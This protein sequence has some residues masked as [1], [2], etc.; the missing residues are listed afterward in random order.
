MQN[1][2]RATLWFALLLIVGLLFY[3]Q[4]KQ[5]FKVETNILKLLPQ[6]EVDPFAEEAFTRFSDNNFKQLIIAVSASDKNGALDGAQRLS[7][8]L[9]ATKLI[10]SF[11][12]QLTQTEQRAIA[13]LYF[14]HRFYLLSDKDRRLMHEE[15][16][17]PFIDDTLQLIY[18]PLS[19]R[20]VSLIP[21]DPYLL[22][23]RYIQNINALNNKRNQAAELVDE[24][25]V[26]NQ[27]GRFTA[28]LSARISSS[29]FDTDTQNELKG[30]IE[31][32]ERQNNE[33]S[34]LRTGALFYAQHAAASAKQ[35][36]STIGLGSLIAVIVLLLVAFRS[37]VPLLL[38]LS[39]LATGIF[40]ALTVVHLTFSSIHILTLV[41]GSSL[42]GVAVDYSFHYFATANIHQR[43]LKHILIAIT[44]GLISSVIGYVALFTAPFPGL[45][46]MA[47][48][49]AV[50]LAGAFFTVVLLFDRIPYKVNTPNWILN[51]FKL[52]FQMSRYVARPT[53]IILLLAAPIVAVFILSNTDENNDNIRQLQ[54]IPDELYQ[55]EL[56]IKALVNA[57]ATNQFF[58]VRA[59]NPPELLRLLDQINPSLEQLV[60]NN[61]MGSYQHLAQFVPALKQQHNN[62][63]LIG[64]YFLQDN[65]R[66]LVELGLLQPDQ[67]DE[68]KQQY[69]NQEPLQLTDWLKSPL[70]QRFNYLWLGQVSQQYA[71]IITLNNIQDIPSLEAAASKHENLYFINKVD[72][73]S[74]M[75]ANYRELA[76]MMLILAIGAVFIVLTLK[77]RALIAGYVLMGPLVA[78]SLAIII[79]IL[80]NNSFN[81]FSTLALF[82]VFGIGI[83]YGLFYAEAKKR[84]SYI[85][86][87][88]GLSAITTLLS[89][90]L[91]SLSQ[92]P[93]IHAFG[94][95][96]LTGILT[97]FLLSPILGHLIYRHK[98][99]KYE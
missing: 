54:S 86:L 7:Q 80:I 21:S 57:P 76:L 3:G 97:V 49:C 40:I 94:L 92:T 50:G 66:E 55:Q 59:D 74:T 30:V 68:L 98:G 91:L 90:G 25:M 20:L 85:S 52:Q 15:G 13:E 81:L 6:T 84:S 48:F 5:G 67:V 73:I 2:Y 99:L 45:R 88:I 33:L 87:A 9:S 60:T 39:S 83:D 17:D 37:S 31:K 11:Q 69:N 61:A 27:N 77:Y 47:L 62:Y 95:T 89:F 38:T 16:R 34:I 71:A 79:N 12:S 23:Y 42:V 8:Q 58:V 72:K 65:Q 96:M 19:G 1:N 93:A 24:F 82:L 32:F 63:N 43:P 35:E 75:F 44:M 64:Q 41:F 4:L 53:F 26:F 56:Q 22:S 46:Q 36:I 29:P 51:C 18:S 70:G 78:G 10:E 28:L 14:N